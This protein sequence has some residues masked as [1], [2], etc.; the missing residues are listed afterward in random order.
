MRSLCMQ[1]MPCIRFSPAWLCSVVLTCKERFPTFHPALKPPKEVDLEVCKGWR[2]GVASC[3]VDV[4]QWDEV[5]PLHAAGEAPLIAGSFSG[6]CLRCDRDIDSQ[7]S[8]L[9]VAEG[10][11]LTSMADVIPRRSFKNN[12]DPCWTFPDQEL[13]DLFRYATSTEAMLVALEHMQ[14]SWVTVY[15]THLHRFKKNVISFPQD[16]VGFFLGWVSCS[17]IALVIA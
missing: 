1:R 15:R 14:V 16:S 12:M 13:A 2:S 8:L 7:R 9:H 11:E 4:A 5:P 10:Q 17:N 6:M 3:D